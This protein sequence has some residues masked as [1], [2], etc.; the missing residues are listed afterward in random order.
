VYGAYQHAAG[1]NSHHL[2][3]RQVDDCDAGLSD[4]FFRLVEFLDSGENDAVSAGA[5]IQNKLEKLLALWNSSAV[6]D[7]DYAEIRLAEGFKVYPVFKQRFNF[8]I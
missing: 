4:Q 2:S 6:L 8:N 5:V 3:R 7:L 1:I